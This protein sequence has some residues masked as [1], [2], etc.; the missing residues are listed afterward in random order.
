VPASAVV[1]GERLAR[2]NS[3]AHLGCRM[4]CVLASACEHINNELS[5]SDST[6]HALG[7]ALVGLGDD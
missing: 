3:H 4:I 2:V 1:H 5:H 7:L 6:V